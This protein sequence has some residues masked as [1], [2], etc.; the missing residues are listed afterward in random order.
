MFVTVG[1]TGYPHRGE[2][3]VGVR[4]VQTF[5]PDYMA[6]IILLLKNGTWKKKG[7]ILLHKNLSQIINSFIEKLFAHVNAYKP[8]Q[9]TGHKSTVLSEHPRTAFLNW[10]VTT[11]KLVADSLGMGRG[12]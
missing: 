10:W 7:Q 1:D 9:T 4:T 2:D 6:F 5:I 12:V 8:I 11:Q 3:K